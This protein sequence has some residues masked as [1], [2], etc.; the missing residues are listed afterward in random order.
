MLQTA[1]PNPHQ[2]NTLSRQAYIQSECHPIASRHEMNAFYREFFRRQICA[3]SSS[4]TTTL[5]PPSLLILRKSSLPLVAKIVSI[6]R[7]LHHSSS[8]LHR[9]R[10]SSSLA[11][12]PIVASLC[13]HSP[14]VRNFHKSVASRSVVV[15]P[16]AGSTADCRHLLPLGTSGTTSVRSI[17]GFAGK[18]STPYLFLPFSSFS[19]TRLIS[20]FHRAGMMVWVSDYDCDPKVSELVPGATKPLQAGGTS[21][22]AYVTNPK[23]QQGESRD[24]VWKAVKMKSDATHS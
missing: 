23:Q 1:Q 18:H 3:A 19:S 11:L 8:A 9:F 17:S 7:T 12:S 5:P 10:L 24:T 16:T 14:C 2:R 4:T 22:R 6:Y 21:V 15:L 13:N 20:A